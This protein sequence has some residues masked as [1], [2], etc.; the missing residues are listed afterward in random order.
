MTQKFV[1]INGK[2]AVEENGVIVFGPFDTYDEMKD[3]IH[4][5]DESQYIV[6]SPEHMTFDVYFEPDACYD[7]EG[8]EVAGLAAI[9]L[10][11]KLIDGHDN[12]G[13]HNVTGLPV[14]FGENP[15]EESENVYFA[16]ASES[17]EQVKEEMIKAGFTY[18]EMGLN[19][20]D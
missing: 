1:D 14:V 9:F 16:Y 11:S 18:E 13:Y 17:V 8:N 20:D 3:N 15:V 6:H 12:L 5:H 10:N 4:K 2:I 7:L 19:Y